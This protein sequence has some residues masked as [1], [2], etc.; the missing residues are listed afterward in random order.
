MMAKASQEICMPVKLEMTCK[1]RTRTRMETG[2]GAKE[3][4]KKKSRTIATFTDT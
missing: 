1:A 4:S 2:T 3:G